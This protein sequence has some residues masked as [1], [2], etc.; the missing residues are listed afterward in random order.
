MS[1]AKKAI[2]DAGLK[3]TVSGEDE[4]IVSQLPK[5]GVMMNEDSIII[6]YTEEKDDEDIEIEVPDVTGLS[7]EEARYSLEVKNLNFEVAGA[8]HSEAYN[9]YAVN[10]SIKAGEKVMPGTVVGVEFRQEASD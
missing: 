6:L 2:T 8:G 3:Y 7:V 1:E 9:A 4:E 5:P 10:Q